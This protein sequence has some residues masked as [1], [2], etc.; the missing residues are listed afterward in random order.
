MDDI[1][2][3]PCNGPMPVNGNYSVD[4][5]STT[6][7]N[8]SSKLNT[9]NLQH[10]N[11]LLLRPLTWT[12]NCVGS[13]KH[14]RHFNP[15]RTRPGSTGSLLSMN[16]SLSAS[17]LKAPSPLPQIASYLD[18]TQISCHNFSHEVL[19]RHGKDDEPSQVRFPRGSA[20]VSFLDI[21]K[22]EVSS[23]TM[24]CLDSH[25]DI[26]IDESSQGLLLQ[27]P[28]L[29]SIVSSPESRSKMI[30][31]RNDL[32]G[33]TRRYAGLNSRKRADFNYC[34]DSS[35]F[36]PPG[37]LAITPSWPV[38]H[39]CNN[40]S[41]NHISDILPRCS[42]DFQLLANYRLE[43]ILR[44]YDS[45]QSRCRTRLLIRMVIQILKLST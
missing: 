38:T 22:E 28:C 45:V 31:D 27:D 11:S 41:Y 26:E 6:K 24:V 17:P 15:A 40:I 1:C 32:K 44:K 34:D 25:I 36:L 18:A 13:E 43:R 12:A 7:P 2:L 14:V 3:E 19:L 33:E 42:R 30:L 5:R 16:Q 20:P 35:L 39:I 8:Q 23:T 4:T 21:E 10:M 29:K 37:P 9:I